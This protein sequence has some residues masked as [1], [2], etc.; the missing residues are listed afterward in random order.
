HDA[1]PVTAIGIGRRRDECRTI[2]TITITAAARTGHTA[3][4]RVGAAVLM[5]CKPVVPAGDD[6]CA[7]GRGWAC[8]PNHSWPFLSAVGC[9]IDRCTRL[10]RPT[11]FA[12]KLVS[13]IAEYGTVLKSTPP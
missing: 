1:A 12:L 5:P 4:S 11:Y 6:S 13:P 8:D 2:R 7:C 9:C 10:G 3:T